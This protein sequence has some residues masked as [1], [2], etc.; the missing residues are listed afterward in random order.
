MRL[1][2][3]GVPCVAGIRSGLL[4]PRPLPPR[5][6]IPRLPIPMLPIPRR[7]LRQ[8]RRPRPAPTRTEIQP[9]SDSRS[10]FYFAAEA[11][12]MGLVRGS[13]EPPFRLNREALLLYLTRFLHANRYPLRWKALY[14]EP[15][16]M[17]T[18]VTTWP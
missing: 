18:G 3:L 7:P 9:I 11:A 6:P 4:L 17:G 14:I 12:A 2:I 5:L 1:P 16:V 15:V 13:I 8:S 10:R